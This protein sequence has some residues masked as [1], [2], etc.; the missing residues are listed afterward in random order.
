MLPAWF[1][2]QCTNNAVAPV[3]SISACVRMKQAVCDIPY[4]LRA[5]FG[6]TLNRDFYISSFRSVRG[7]YRKN[8]STKW[9]ASLAVPR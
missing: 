1:E 7:K 3:Q 2:K 8:A 5:P 4:D 9:I 6:T